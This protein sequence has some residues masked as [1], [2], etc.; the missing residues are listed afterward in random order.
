[1]LSDG[2]NRIPENIDIVC[3][4]G[5]SLNINE[6]A[7]EVSDTLNGKYGLVIMDALY[8]FLPDKCDE[9]KNG[10]MLHVYNTLDAIARRNGCAIAVIHHSSKGDQSQ[11][12]STDVGSGAGVITRATDSHLIMRR[13]EL[14]G[15]AVLELDPRSW[16]KI[17]PQTIQF[18]F[19]LWTAKHIP[20]AI[21]QS[22]ST[23]DIKQK[24]QDIE[25]DQKILKAL[26]GTKGLSRPQLRTKTGYGQD[27]VNR[28]IV[29]LLESEQVTIGKRKNR[30]NGKRIEV[31]QC[32]A[33]CTA[34]CTNNSTDI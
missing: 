22:K 29:R 3:V 26:E 5:Q 34:E 14:D 13:H 24:N 17:E 20:P 10:D 16:P 4:R 8:R 1:M 32:T 21:K 15:C 7:L 30:K 6:I 27:R 23:R 31:I 11:K 12:D 2:V 25:A 28:A 19:P 33:E 18:E 9:S